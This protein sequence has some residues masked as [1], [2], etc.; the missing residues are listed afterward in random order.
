[1]ITIVTIATYFVAAFVGAS[2]KFVFDQAMNSKCM[3]RRNAATVVREMS[4]LE[5]G[6]INLNPSNVIPFESIEEEIAYA[7]NESVNGGMWIFGT[8]SGTGK[9]TYLD[10]CI[11]KFRAE[12]PGRY[13]VLFHTG[14]AILTN[15][16]LHAHFGVPQNESLSGYIPQGTIIVIDQVDCFKENISLQTKD[17]I[18]QLATTSYNSKSFS[19]IVSVS[20]P[21]VMMELLKLN[22]YEKIRDLCDPL[23]AKWTDVEARAYVN[24]LFQSWSEHE[25]NE[26]ILAC[27][28]I[29]SPSVLHQACSFSK[30]NKV[31]REAVRN[32]AKLWSSQKAKEWEEYA[33]EFKDFTFYT[34]F[35]DHYN[36]TFVDIR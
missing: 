21:S 4:A 23:F 1:M 33:E 11:K 2:A 30:T 35:V 7:L 10:K 28:G 18:L 22:G 15:G 13:V 31:N 16:G 9:S 34:P 19:I 5:N 36:D 29:Y 26:L 32:C 17:Y 25:K 27:G 6:L 12:N 14:I 3:R 24:K 20:K 8:P